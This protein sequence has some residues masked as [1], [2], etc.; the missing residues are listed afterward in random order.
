MQ[1]KRFNQLKIKLKYAYAFF[2]IFEFLILS[3]LN[4]FFCFFKLVDNH[5][6]CIF[7]FDFE[8]G[9]LKFSVSSTKIVGEFFDFEFDLVTQ[10][11]NQMQQ[12]QKNWLHNTDFKHMGITEKSNFRIFKRAEQEYEHKKVP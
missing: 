5:F 12:S 3:W 11:F 2:N 1:K 9:Q 7:E 4:H 6:F 10:E 8:L